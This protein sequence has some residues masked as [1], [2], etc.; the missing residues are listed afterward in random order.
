[1]STLAGQLQADLKSLRLKRCLAGSPPT[2]CAFR[3]RIL[4]APILAETTFAGQIDHR[5]RV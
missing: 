1:M 2:F 5:V 4:A 3:R